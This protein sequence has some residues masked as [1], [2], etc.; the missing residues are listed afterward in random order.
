MATTPEHKLKHLGIR[1]TPMRLKIIDLFMSSEGKALSNKDLE[2]HLGESDRITVYRTLKTFEQKGLIHQVVDGTGVTK[3]AICV[4]ECNDHDHHDEHAH[5]R[6]VKCSK[7][8]CLEG[9]I[10]LPNDIPA[11]YKV[12]QAHLVLEGECAD[13]G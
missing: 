4:D 10:Q 5:F 6:C 2:A 13:C 9:T 1:K 8:I 7:T 3:Y 12:V 11:G